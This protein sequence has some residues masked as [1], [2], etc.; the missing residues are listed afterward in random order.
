M[1]Q[2]SAGGG[3]VSERKHRRRRVAA[4]RMKRLKFKAAAGGRAAVGGA[5]GR[6][7]WAQITIELAVFTLLMIRLSSL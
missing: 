1:E 3:Q 4:W 2:R 6:L 5:P 7:D